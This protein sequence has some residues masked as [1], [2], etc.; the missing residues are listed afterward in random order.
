MATIVDIQTEQGGNL[1]ANEGG[2]PVLNVT[3]YDED[4]DPVFP[5]GI[6]FTLYSEGCPSQIINDRLNQSVLDMNG[7]TLTGSTLRLVLGAAD[8]V[9]VTNSDR[10][11]H[12][13]KF[14]YDWLREETEQATDMQFGRFWVE[15][16]KTPAGA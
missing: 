2:S 1:F 3:F 4:G 15:R 10:E 11:A 13:T 8:N 5:T 9:M 6:R 12:I 14:E 16:D 7:G